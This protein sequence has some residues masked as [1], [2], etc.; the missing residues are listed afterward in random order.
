MRKKIIIFKENIANFWKERTNAQKSTLIGSVLA[1]VIVLLAI[2]ILSSKSNMVPL[3]QNLSLQEIGQMKTELD[4]RNV[5]YELTQGGQ[6][7]LVPESQVDGLLVDLAASGLP[8]SGNIDYSFFS[9]NT[10]WGM[11]D[12]E[13][14]MIKLDT[15][16]TELANLMKG[17][18][19]IKDAQVMINQPP[20]PV[21]IGDE[22]QEATASIVLHTSPGYQFKDNQLEGLYNLVSKSVPNLTTDNIVIMNQYFEYF[23][24]KSS[25]SPGSGNT[26][27]QQ[28]NIKK[29][30]ER[31]IQRRVQQ[32]L[33]TMIGLDKVV[34]SVTTD[35]DFT[36]E[37]RIEELVEPV[38]PDSMEGLPVSVER[39]TETYTGNPPMAGGAPAG[40]DD[41]AAYN[42]EDANDD[43][44]YEMV[45]E[46]INNEFDRI[47]REIVESPY[48][49]RDIGIQ[50]AIDTSKGLDDAGE[51]QLL[52]QQE[53]A[54][55][56]ASVSS[57]L[58]SIIATSVAAPYEGEAV[59]ENVSIVFQ[60]FNG[61]EEQQP[62]PTGIPLWAY[63]AGG[64]LL[65]VILTLLWA[66]LRRNRDQ[67]EDEDSYQEFMQET[68]AYDIPE[69]EEEK[70]TE[71][72]VKR[73]QLERMA[74]EKP[75]DFAKLLRSWIAED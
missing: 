49:I 74:R 13:F 18:E 10:S 29:D 58:D 40:E 75:E 59:G 28:Q 67:G 35:I 60:E 15:M 47:Q 24:Q 25:Y 30:I 20:E 70:D 57:I 44:E 36:Q 33:G 65:A 45:K 5:N 6:T 61:A 51:V 16:Q 54:T 7:I 11:T 66:V 22:Q 63:I 19:G 1:L 4:A 62:A 48:K 3:Y 53:Q 34:A 64:V 52:S 50:V 21:F 72:T 43:G 68:A 56:E 31:D 23:D 39:L 69:L 12:N 26:Y 27:T 14:D 8:K 55:V 42:A 38:D 73:K 71:G 9:E 46:T 32:M 17:I 2:S 37:N 41:P